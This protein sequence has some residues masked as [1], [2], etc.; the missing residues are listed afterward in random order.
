MSAPRGLRLDGHKAA[1]LQ[2]PLQVL[3]PPAVVVLALD[4]GSGT[5]A[6]ALVRTGQAVRM[7]TRVAAGRGAAADL[8]APVSGVVREVG[9]GPTLRGAAPCIVIENDGRDEPEP[10]VA[11]LDWSALDGAAL[12]ERIADAGIAGLG[13]A[14][15]PT[16]TKLARAREARVERLLLNGAECEPWI[17]CDDALLRERAPQVVLG[18]QVLLA[19]TGALEC[20]IAIEEDKPAAIAAVEAALA[21]A[22]DARIAVVTLPCVFPLG[23]E[24]PLVTAVTGREVPRGGLPPDIGVL[25]QNVGTAA[26]VAELAARGA[27][28]T[29][30]IVTVTGSGVRM[31]ANVE[32]RLGTPV[33]DLVAACGGYGDA[34]RRLIAGGSLTG[35]PFADDAAALTKGLNCVLVATDQDLPS[36]GAEMPCIRCGDCGVVCPANLLPQHLHVAALADDARLLDRLGLDACIECGCCDFVCPSVIPLTARFRAA[37]ARQQLLAADRQRA[38]EARTRYERHQR[39]MAALGEEERR[40]FDEAR[41]RA[42]DRDSGGA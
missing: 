42:A 8:H 24:A 12:I 20:T 28:L 9:L 13:G 34:A 16:A 7:G 10:D 11:V 25:C 31:P 5:A 2:R 4:Q 19:A 33:A 29:R 39:R 15:F 21:T 27:P 32:A 18:A 17:C 6:E 1:S 26:A 3:A 40:A 14:A 35:R 23:A 36:R 22:G 38:Q 30:R 37:R 41:R